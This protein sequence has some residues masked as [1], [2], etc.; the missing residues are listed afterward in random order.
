MP[1]YWLESRAERLPV[2]F[3]QT[4]GAWVVCGILPGIFCV[5]FGL[6]VLNRCSIKIHCDGVWSALDFSVARHGLK[7]NIH[8]REASIFLRRFQRLWLDHGGE[9]HLAASYR[10]HSIPFCTWKINIGRGEPFISS[11]GISGS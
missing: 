6:Q 3:G 5:I 9:S 1:P 4:F 11:M 2:F 8:K 10:P 7:K